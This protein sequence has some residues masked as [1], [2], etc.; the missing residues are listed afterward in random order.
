MTILDL[1]GVLAGLLTV[2]GVALGL[3]GVIGTTKPVGPPSATTRRIARWWTGAGRSPRARRTRQAMIVAAVTGGALAWLITGW[4]AAALIVGVAIPGVPWLF[5]AG[6]AEKRAIARLE[7]VE[8]WTR[9]LADIVARGLGLQQAIVATT[10]TAPQAI[11]QEV[12]DLAARLQATG[13]P[14]AAL[15][16]FADDIDDYTGDQ[17]VA[18]LILHLGDRGDGVH[19]VLADISRSIAAE[20]EMRA[21]VDAKREAPRF[22]VRFLTGMTVALIAYGLANPDYLAPYRTPTGQ[23]LLIVLAAIYVV[24]MMAVRKLSL[25]PVRSRLLRPPSDLAEGSA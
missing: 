2:G 8:A 18:P 17:V 13:E 25:P 11:Q 12:L 1:A 10:A 4:P 21:T 22:A 6:S 5:A 16:Q 15:R 7:A 23:I 14:V 24:L 20:I 19:N 9:R 3:T